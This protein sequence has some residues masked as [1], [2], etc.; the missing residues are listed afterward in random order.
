MSYNLSLLLFTYIF[1]SKIKSGPEYNYAE[2]LLEK[3][4][5]IKINVKKSVNISI[6]TYIFVL[7]W[8]GAETLPKI[9]KNV[10]NTV[11]K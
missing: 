3:T 8:I 4:Y 9:L 5:I 11:Y 6:E 1:F 10:A 2:F 7:Y